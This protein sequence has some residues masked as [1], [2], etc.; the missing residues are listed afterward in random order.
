MRK[1]LIITIAAALLLA[2]VICT[3]GCINGTADPIAGAWY[4]KDGGSTGGICLIFDEDNTGVYIYDAGAYENEEGVPGTGRA[5]SSFNWKAEEDNAYFIAFDD[6]VSTARLTMN[7]D[8]KTFTTWN[9]IVYINASP[10]YKPI[11]TFDT[12]ELIR[13]SS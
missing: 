12:A 11:P 9:D 2:A 5:A 1:S 3:A 13:H 6:H 7:P 10:G 8:G 4:T